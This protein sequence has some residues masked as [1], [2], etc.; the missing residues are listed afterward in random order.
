MT[1]ESLLEESSDDHVSPNNPKDSFSSAP[2][3]LY[4]SF[5]RF[6]KDTVEAK[7]RWLYSMLAASSDRIFTL[8]G[9]NSGAGYEGNPLESLPAGYIGLGQTF[10]ISLLG[11]N[12]GGYIL[13]R[14]I[15]NDKDLKKDAIGGF[16]MGIGLGETLASVHDYMVLGGYNLFGLG[17]ISLEKFALIATPLV[18]LP[19]AYSRL[20]R[21]IHKRRAPSYE[22]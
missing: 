22:K 12:V 16:Y 8:L 13:S 17:S 21:A 20:K 5:K 3:R 14:I 9:V 19:F 10:L 1:L 2:H 11:I 6:Y 7:F 4:S 15:N 18:I